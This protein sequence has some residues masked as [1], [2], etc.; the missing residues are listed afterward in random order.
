[1]A[2]YPIVQSHFWRFVDLSSFVKHIGNQQHAC[3]RRQAAS[4]RRKEVRKRART[5]DRQ[6]GRRSTGTPKLALHGVRWPVTAHAAVQKIKEKETLCARAC[7]WRILLYKA[8]GIDKA[9]EVALH[10]RVSSHPPLANFSPGP[11]RRASSSTFSSRLEQR[12]AY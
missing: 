7:R 4:Q 8:E 5:G 12:A 9:P 6:S 1:M 2:R 10:N 3:W 11:Q